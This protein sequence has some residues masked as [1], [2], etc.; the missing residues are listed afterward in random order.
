ML[1]KLI[2]YTLIAGV[3]GT[4]LGGLIGSLF[5]RDSTKTMSLLL[6][7]AGGIMLSVVC[8][9]LI[10]SSI[11]HSNVWIMSLVVIIG[12]ILL[13]FLNYWVDK[14]TEKHNA[15]L[16]GTH[17]KTADDLDEITHSNTLI[18]RMSQKESKRK[19]LNAG[20]IM[21][22]AIALHNFPEGLSIGSSYS[23]E[24]N[25]GI[26]LAIIIALHNIPEGM[27]IV[28]PL[29]C[30]GM[31]KGKA[32][33]LTAISGFPTV[34][35]AILGYLVGGAG[36]LSLSVSLALASGAMIYVVFGE[37]IPQAFLM[38]KS[39]MPTIFIIIGI[40]MGIILINII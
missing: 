36:D 10:P 11:D 24:N 23:H 21:V 17:P 33:F 32:V 7:F 14:A 40:L 1:G 4:G 12:V 16:D 20:I 38:L 19:L 35:G 22:L 28:T 13:Y 18:H 30:G 31:N 25:M 39:K 37:I 8:F 15:H 5:K 29:I 3:G 34:L 2:L 9:D 26:I 6:S 27:A